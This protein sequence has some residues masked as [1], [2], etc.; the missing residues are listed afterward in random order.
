MNH[1]YRQWW[2]IGSDWSNVDKY[3]G[4][5]LAPLATMNHW[6]QW[7]QWIAIV[8]NGEPLA[9]MDPMSPMD[10]HWWQWIQW[11]K[12]IHWCQWMA[13][14]R[15]CD[16]RSSV[17]RKWYHWRHFV[18]ANGN[19]FCH[20]RQK[21]YRHWRQWIANGAIGSPKVLFFV[22][23]SDSIWPFCRI[24]KIYVVHVIF[25]VVHVICIRS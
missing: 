12:W 13:D 18:V 2:I 1:H 11:R 3:N 16:L 22:A 6:R 25:Y 7:R 8:D 20:W 9:P 10:R 15:Q 5:P 23:N 21:M 17:D 14:N 24:S 4:D 19:G